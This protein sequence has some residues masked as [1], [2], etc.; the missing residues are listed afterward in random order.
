VT[1]DKRYAQVAWDIARARA[2]V[3]PRIDWSRPD[4]V[5]M[6]FYLSGNKFVRYYLMSMLVGLGQA[7]KIGLREDA[8]VRFS[9][10][11]IAIDMAA[12][13]KPAKGRAYLRPRRDG[14]FV[15]NVALRSRWGRRF[16]PLTIRVTDGRGKVVAS[17][18]AEWKPRE[19][20]NRF[21]PIGFQCDAHTFSIPKA[22]KGVV[23][24]LDLE[25]ADGQMTVNIQADA[26][27]VIH[28]PL[29]GQTDFHNLSGQTASGARV[30]TRTTSDTITFGMGHR[31]P[32]SI[33]DSKTWKLLYK[34][35]AQPDSIL[36]VK[37]GKDR[38]I[39]ICTYGYTNIMRVRGGV[40][41]YYA[42]TRDGWFEPK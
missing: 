8:P 1:G 42:T 21:Y 10:T 12:D 38:P 19:A 41:P 14:D 33:R 15:V 35:P 17:T 4:K 2:D 24:R 32:F 6:P 13:K 27:V 34:A 25:G 3:T 37:V 11:H 26:D 5:R 22:R 28:V 31:A 40:A 9:D 30:Y 7:Q 36:K 16:K 39:V 23:Y 18:R 20:K 29:G